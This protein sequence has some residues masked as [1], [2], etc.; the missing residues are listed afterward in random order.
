MKKTLRA[1][2]EVDVNLAKSEIADPEAYLAEVI[3]IGLIK[4]SGKLSM[5]NIKIEVDTLDENEKPLV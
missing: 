1:T 5:T 2:V 4:G 3:S